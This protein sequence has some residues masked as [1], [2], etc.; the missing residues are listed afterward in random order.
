MRTVAGAGKPHRNPGDCER[1]DNDIFLDSSNQF[2]RRY[3][4]YLVLLPGRRDSRQAP[5]RGEEMNA[6]HP[7]TFIGLVCSA[8][9][10]VPILT[11]IVLKRVALRYERRYLTVQLDDGESDYE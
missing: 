8:L 11:G 10:V 9:V 3:G 4:Y 5:A 7:V 2:Y 6:L 1:C